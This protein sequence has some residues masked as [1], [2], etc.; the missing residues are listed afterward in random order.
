MTTHDPKLLQELEQERADQLAARLTLK[1]LEAIANDT[2]LPGEIA[3]AYGV[4][5][6]VIAR[7]QHKAR[8]S[9]S[10]KRAAARRKGE[11][12]E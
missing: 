1:Q 7:I 2:R 4:T 3:G 6:A 10:Q 5:A 11:D 9:K 12:R 8:V